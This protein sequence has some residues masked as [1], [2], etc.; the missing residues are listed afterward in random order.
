MGT[1]NRA[2]STV[3]LKTFFAAVLFSSGLL[4]F[5]PGSDLLAAG[6]LDSL[7]ILASP[8][9]SPVPIPGP[10]A[11]FPGPLKPSPAL[12]AYF[13]NVGQGD[14]EYIVLPNGKNVLI[15]G[16]PNPTAP[17]IQFLTQN[18]VSK[19]DYVVLTHPH[20]DH[21]A[22]LDYVFTHLKVG[23]FYDTREDNTGAAGAKLL[24]DKI[25]AM[26]IRTVYPA[27]GDSLDW[28]PGEVQVNVLNACATPGGSNSGP[29]LNNCSIVFKVTYQD[30]S[31]LYTGDIQAEQEANLVAK[32]GGRLRSLVLKVCHHGSNTSSSP[33]FLNMVKP[34]YAYI[35]VGKDNI[36]AFPSPVTLA[37]LQAVGAT[38]YRTDLDGTQQFN[39]GG[40]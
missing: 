16:G 36:F 40:R 19:L 26:G 38:V 34:K 12:Q 21:Y 8:L 30:T 11:P 24:R 15:D 27:A 18:G 31:M 9:P 6:A 10:P 33:A 3:K 14:A 20:L 2:R 37:N 23:T 32:Y 17:L 22:G 5:A 39:I 13:V 4:A 25:S 35:G 1:R 7:S 29:V 28:D